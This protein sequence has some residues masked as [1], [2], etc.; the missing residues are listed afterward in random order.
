[1]NKYRSNLI[2]S[3]FVLI[4]LLIILVVITVSHLSDIKNLALIDTRNMSESSDHQGSD[5]CDLSGLTCYARETSV[6]VGQQAHFNVEGYFN[7]SHLGSGGLPSACYK[8]NLRFTW[9]NLS[10]G[11][12]DGINLSV[13]ASTYGGTAKEAK[14]PNV[15]VVPVNNSDGDGSHEC[16]IL[17]VN[18]YRNGDTEPEDSFVAWVRNRIMNESFVYTDKNISGIGEKYNAV[19]VR[20]LIP[21]NVKAGD[22]SNA[23]LYKNSVQSFVTGVVLDDNPLDPGPKREALVAGHSLGSIAAYNYRIENQQYLSDNSHKAEVQ[24]YLYDPPYSVLTILPKWLE[25]FVGWQAGLCVPLPFGDGPVNG[26]E[27]QKAKNYGIANTGAL[28]GDWTNGLNFNQYSESDINYY[29]TL[30]TKQPSVLD[31]IPNWVEDKCSHI[32][33][34]KI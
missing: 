14:C 4:I 10:I 7:S 20:G 25:A 31:D 16:K 26:C 30:Y 24:F 32:Y 34:P 17:L 12:K 15:K 2:T 5:D 3:S 11:T 19:T 33:F 18:G 21:G 13:V 23:I 22:S 29:H 27:I 9:K 6:E 28:K 1:M 8:K